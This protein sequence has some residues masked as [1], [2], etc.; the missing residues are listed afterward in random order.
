MFI[1]QERL[2][3]AIFFTVV[4][5]ACL[6]VC[7]TASA[8]PALTLSRKSAAPASK[9]LVNWNQFHF[10]PNHKGL[11]PYEHVL[12]VN[13]V[14]KLNLK[15]S[16]TT[17]DSILSSLAV[18]KGLVYVGSWDDNVY[19][20]KASTGAKLWSYTTG[21]EVGSSAAVANG[22]V[23]IGSADNQVYVFG[24]KHG[25]G[26]PEAAYK[27]P[28]RKATGPDLSLQTAEQLASRSGA[29][30]GW[31]QTGCLPRCPDAALTI[32][33]VGKTNDKPLHAPGCTRI[34]K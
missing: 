7:A 21:S 10:T 5:L 12:N 20:L 32:C 26:K 14:G 17:G 9:I 33:R 6:S 24:L 31:S 28:G 4:A 11:N 25:W 13:N 27:R 8:A 1:R 2:Q 30:Q 29:D 15:W 3:P 19:A 18:A 34:Q 16:Y 22:K 23:Y